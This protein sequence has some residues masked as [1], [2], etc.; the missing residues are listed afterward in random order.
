MEAAK[1]EKQIPTCQ[2]CGK[3]GHT[4]YG[5]HDKELRK[6]WFVQNPEESVGHFDCQCPGCRRRYSVNCKRKD[7]KEATKCPFCFPRVKKDGNS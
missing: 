6:A 5:C 7:M 3:L 1:I 2:G 4:I